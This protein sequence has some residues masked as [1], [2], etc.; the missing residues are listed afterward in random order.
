MTQA[1]LARRTYFDRSRVAHLERGTARA[2]QRFWV[3]ADEAVGADGSLVAAYVEL[4][5]AKQ[6]LAAEA[7]ARELADDIDHAAMSDA[8]LDDWEHT[9][10]R[11][12]LA[13]RYRPA[14]SQ[15]VDLTA[16]FAELRRL[17]ESR[18]AILVPTRLTRIV[19]QMARLVASSLN[20]LD[21]PAAARS[22]ARMAKQVAKDAG[23]S[24]LHASVL[25]EEAY[26]HYYNSNLVEASTSRPMLNTSPAMRR[27][28]VSHRPLP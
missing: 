16:D 9:V 14:A 11:Y 23:D 25:T 2:D 1:Q 6:T 18:S 8:S 28:Q 5:T 17:L 15:L 3:A 22:W 13:G 21:Q 26:T 27:A 10:Y 4:E 24:Q 19:A 12:G 20:R 7:R